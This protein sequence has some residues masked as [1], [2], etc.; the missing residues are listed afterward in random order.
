MA[1]RKAELE[2]KKEK[3]RQIREEKERRKR[4]REAEEA[5]ASALKTASGE[6]G[7]AQAHHDINAQLKALGVTPV[8]DVLSQLPAVEREQRAAAEAATATASE[9]AEGGLPSAAAGVSPARRRAAPASLGITA[10]HQTSIPPRLNETYS[11]QTQTFESGNDSMP[12]RRGT[13]KNFYTTTFFDDPE[14][15]YEEDSM[16]L[17]SGMFAILTLSFYFQR[18]ED[19]T[20]LC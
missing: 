6:A 1:D 11:K 3:L 7:S 20:V 2:R 10:V 14:E 13:D 19:G 5:K 18:N 12:S 8:S 9:A 16:G 17:G 4:E 15:F